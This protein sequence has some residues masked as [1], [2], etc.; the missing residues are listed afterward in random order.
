ML[1]GA[2]KVLQQK[3]TLEIYKVCFVNAWGWV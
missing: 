1:M 2:L 3:Q